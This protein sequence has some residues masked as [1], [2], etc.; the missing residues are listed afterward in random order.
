M[1]HLNVLGTE[2]YLHATPELLQ[3][4]SQRLK[5]RLALRQ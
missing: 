1:G 2:V 4:A 5:R 3:L